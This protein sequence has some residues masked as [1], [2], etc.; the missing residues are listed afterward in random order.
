MIRIGVSEQALL[1]HNWIYGLSYLISFLPM[2]MR[3]VPQ[4]EQMMLD[5]FG[6]QYQ[7]YMRSTGRVIAK[8]RIN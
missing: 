2:Y 5:T 4:E 6:E 3:R 1:L 8:R 7:E